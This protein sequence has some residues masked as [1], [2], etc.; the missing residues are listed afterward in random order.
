MKLSSLKTSTPISEKALL[1]A[2]L[3]AKLAKEEGVTTC[4]LDLVD[5]K[6]IE[7]KNPLNKWQKAL[8]KII[9]ESKVFT[10]FVEDTESGGIFFSEGSV[11]VRVYA[12]QKE[13]QINIFS[14][15]SGKWLD[16]CCVE[17]H[18]LPV[19]LEKSLQLVSFVSNRSKKT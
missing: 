14:T 17:E 3:K 16:L 18:N 2:E 7:S 5:S 10:S 8:S 19:A 15:E 1:L 11:Q 9:T 6:Q 13:F 12:Y 4:D